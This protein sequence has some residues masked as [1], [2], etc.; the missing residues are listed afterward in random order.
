M[1]LEKFTIIAILIYVLFHSYISMSGFGL[2]TKEVW[3]L[4]SLL[5]ETLYGLEIAA[6]IKKESEGLIVYHP[7]SLYPTLSRLEKSGRTSFKWGKEI[8]GRPRRGYYT[9]TEQGATDIKEYYA[10][11]QRLSVKS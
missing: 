3:L 11:C 8:E 4:T 10:F 6:K 5:E 1:F 9:L 2:T 7:Q